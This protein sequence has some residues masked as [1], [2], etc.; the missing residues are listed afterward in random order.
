MALQGSVPG[1]FSLPLYRQHVVQADSISGSQPQLPAYAAY[2]P[3]RT[4]R[5]ACSSGSSASA[6]VTRTAGCLLLA[7]AMRRIAAQGRQGRIARKSR[8]YESNIKYKVGPAQAKQA[9]TV[10][11]HMARIGIAI[12]EGGGTD[13]ENNPALKAAIKRALKDNVP[14]AP[15]DKKLKAKDDA[16]TTEFYMGGFGPNGVAVLIH[17]VTD[18]QQETRVAVGKAFKAVAGQV[19]NDGSVD[20][21]FNKQGTIRFEGVNEEAVMEASLEADVED[22]E[23]LDDGGVQ[24]TTAPDKFHAALKVFESQGLEPAFAEVEF[25]PLN[26][27]ELDKKGTYNIKRMLHELE[28]SDGVQSIHHNGEFLDGIELQFQE[29]LGL[30]LVVPFSKL[31]S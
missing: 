20:Y 7:G 9:R 18:N 22:C 28:E 3:Q 11:R 6:V 29:M 15:I 19:G 4:A 26:M 16:E 10:K 23:P 31:A 17:C 13:E 21:C 30:E 8:N 14:R 2:A 24:V 25:V 27:A 1:H 5:P 12:R